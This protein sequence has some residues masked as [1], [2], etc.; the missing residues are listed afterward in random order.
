[1]KK[2]ICLQFIERD[3]RVRPLSVLS[4][5]AQKPLFRL[6]APP[7]LS[8]SSRRHVLMEV[9]NHDKKV[10]IKKHIVPGR[11]TNKHGYKLETRRGHETANQKTRILGAKGN[12]EQIQ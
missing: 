2:N 4:T 11:G 6:F 8:P 7:L 9:K 12:N 1:M 10:K 3:Y 5:R